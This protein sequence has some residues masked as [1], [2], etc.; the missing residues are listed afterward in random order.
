MDAKGRS[1]ILVGIKH[2]GKTTMGTMLA[3]RLGCPFFDTD[4]IIAASAKMSVRS[5]YRTQGVEAFM[6]A[7]ENACTAL[8]SESMGKQ[9]VIATGGGICTNPPAVDKLRPLGPFVFLQIPEARAID[10]IIAEANF[11]PAG[12]EN[13]PAFIAAHNPA[14]KDD[15]RRIF[16]TFYEERNRLYQKMASV[17]VDMEDASIEVNFAKIW[18]AIA[19]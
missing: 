6:L 17:T 16:H 19:S 9:Y 1:Y 5:L 3:R 2:S 18:A 11:T 8:K 15:V 4:D 13:I 12:I 14:S 7:E 10:R